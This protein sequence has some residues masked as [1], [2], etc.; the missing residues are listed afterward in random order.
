MPGNASVGGAGCVVTL[1]RAYLAVLVSLPSIEVFTA[2]SP[3][4]SLFHPTRTSGFAVCFPVSPSLVAGGLVVEPIEAHRQCPPLP[5]PSLPILPK[6]ASFSLVL[7][8]AFTSF[9]FGY[10]SCPFVLFCWSVCRRWTTRK[11][12]S[13][14]RGRSAGSSPVFPNLMFPEQ[15][16]RERSAGTAVSSSDHDQQ[17]AAGVVRVGFAFSQDPSSNEHEIRMIMRNR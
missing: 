9:W 11:A 6:P 13:Y 8:Y 16:P 12:F 15:L 3:L 5:P 10:V 17:A 2:Y 7:L 1:R 4:S 14:T